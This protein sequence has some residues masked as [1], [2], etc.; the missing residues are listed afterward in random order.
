[1]SDLISSNFSFGFRNSKSLLNVAWIISSLSNHGSK[2][3]T[4]CGTL[5]SLDIC[6]HVHTKSFQ[7]HSKSHT[8]STSF[9]SYVVTILLLM[10]LNQL[11]CFCVHTLLYTHAHTHMHAHIIVIWTFVHHPCHFKRIS[12][13]ILWPIH[14]RKCIIFYYMFE[15]T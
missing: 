4:P 15:F 5:F 14:F 6:I 8:T 3:I 13:E 9:T 2:I 1:M 7:I 11:N 10:V 12:S